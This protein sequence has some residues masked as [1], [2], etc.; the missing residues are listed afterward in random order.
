MLLVFWV[1]FTYLEQY[2]ERKEKELEKSLR[3]SRRVVRSI[4]SITKLFISKTLFLIPYHDGG[5][6]KA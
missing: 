6:C 3:S 1:L 2:A 5:S 4:G